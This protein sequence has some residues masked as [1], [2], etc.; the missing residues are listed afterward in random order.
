MVEIICTILSGIFAIIS[1]IF[2]GISIYNNKQANKQNIWSGDNC[3]NIQLGENNNDK[4]K[5][6][7]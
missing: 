3:N 7:N 5:S 6:R 2:G 4:K 1:T